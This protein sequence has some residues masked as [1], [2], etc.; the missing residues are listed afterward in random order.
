VIDLYGM[1]SPNV[2]KVVL[3]LEET[4][5]PYRFHWVNVWK[6]EQFRPEFMR[7]NPNCKVP[8]IVDEDG[9]GGVFTLCESGAILMYL[10]EKTGRLLPAAYG[11]QRY[12]VLEWYMVQLTGVGPMFGQQVHFKRFAPEGNDYSKSRYRTEMLRLMDLLEKRLGEV[13][14][15]AGDEYSLADVSTYPWI[16]PMDFL[17]LDPTPYPNV[18]RWLQSIADRPAGRRFLT[19]LAELRP[20]TTDQYKQ[21]SADDLD[22][23]FGRGQYARSNA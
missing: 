16:R 8:V 12:A 13:P 20:I 19:K 14:Y 11:P 21:A 4:E 23:F 22:R 3:M 17:G 7:L 2:L 1:T 6:G 18:G 15:L 9:P 5:L 10:A